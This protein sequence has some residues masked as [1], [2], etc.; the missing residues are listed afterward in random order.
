MTRNLPIGAAAVLVG[1]SLL[2]SASV[3]AEPAADAY[4][5]VARYCGAHATYTDFVDEPL[6]G[7]RASCGKVAGDNPVWA[8][9]PGGWDSRADFFFNSGSWN[10]CI[11]DGEY[12]GGARYMMRAGEGIFYP[13]RVSSNRWVQA[14]FWCP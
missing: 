12:Y 14:G 13:D 10:S 1:L 9:L 8:W 5:G 7:G 11:Y 4:N 6:P 2:S 3:N